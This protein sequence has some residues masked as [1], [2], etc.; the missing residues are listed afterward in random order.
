MIQVTCYPMEPDSILITVQRG[1]DGN[2][3]FDYISK[4]NI[5]KEL[6]WNDEKVNPSEM[7]KDQL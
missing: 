6:S 7:A 4:Q 5:I 1:W 2:E 3:V